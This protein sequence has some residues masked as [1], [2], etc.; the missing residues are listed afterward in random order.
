MKTSINAVVQNL[1]Q[2]ITTV[3]EAV[4]AVSSGRNKSPKATKTSQRTSEQASALEETS[5]SM[6]EMTSTVKQNADNAKQANQLAIAARDIADK[7]VPS[8]SV[9]L[10]RWA[11]STRAARRSRTSSP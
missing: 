10:K 3:R 8:P 9:R 7:G 4:Q 6:E 5:A 1:T 2:T 11:R